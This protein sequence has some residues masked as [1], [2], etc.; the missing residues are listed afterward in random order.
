MLITKNLQSIS[1]QIRNKKV[2]LVVVVKNRTI[3]EV[4]EVYDA[5]HRIFGE[6]K[7]QNLLEKYKVLPKDVQWH[8]IGHLQRNKVKYIISFVVLIHSVDSKKLLEEIDT[9]ADQCGRKINCLL[10]IRIAQEKTKYGLQKSEAQELLDQYRQ[11]QYPNV[12]IKGL[13]GFATKT[14]DQ[15][16]IKSE[17]ENLTKYFQVVK[18][19]FFMDD[20]DFDTLSMGMT[21]DYHIALDEGTT[22]IRLGRQIFDS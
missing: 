18:H 4:R 21:N 8:F 3:Q 5:D 17:F 11:G 12:C 15:R 14:D 2:I 22:M 9:K 10:Q 6:N 20:S 19:D 13:M 1:Q 16:L 7:V